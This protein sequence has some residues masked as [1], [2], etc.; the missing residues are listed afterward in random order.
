[1]TVI[2]GLFCDIDDHDAIPF[3]HQWATRR[4]PAP[5]SV[6]LTTTKD[7]LHHIE[8]WKALPESVT[9]WLRINY[10]YHPLG[11]LPEMNPEIIRKWFHPIVEFLRRER[12]I[13]GIM[14]GNEPNNP[15]EHPAGRPLRPE[16]VGAWVGRFWWA[17]PAWMW[18]STPPVDPF[19]AT[20]GSPYE[21]MA[22]MI[23]NATIQS[24]RIE[25]IAVQLKTQTSAHPALQEPHT[26]TDPP[27]TGKSM[28]FGAAFELLH[29]IF[30]PHKPKAILIPECN[31]QR[32]SLSPTPNPHDTHYGWPDDPVA[33]QHWI[34]AALYTAELLSR[35]LHNIPIYLHFYRWSRDAWA[36]RLRPDI[37]HT[38]LSL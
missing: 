27:L 13:R 20:M 5:I 4:H 33:A 36:I 1:M 32:K 18:V 12:R 38:L 8:P 26:F 15:T 9:I 28:N 11:T 23:H 17:L 22:T 34:H 29:S 35:S 2:P 10:G 14:V 6:I 21:Y 3:L 37:H 19:N 7:Q 30:P 16:D 25:A 24:T 31:P